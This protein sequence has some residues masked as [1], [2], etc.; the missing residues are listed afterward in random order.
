[1]LS[2]GR[3][4]ALPR[5]Q[6]LRATLDWSYNLLSESERGLLRHVA[7]FPAGFTLNAAAAVIG[8]RT[9]RVPATFQAWSRSHS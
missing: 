4:T 2:G 1:L 9:T 3:R 8:D 6:T 7:V 5:H